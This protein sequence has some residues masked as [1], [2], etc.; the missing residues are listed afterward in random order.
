MNYFLKVI[1][2]HETPDEYF[3]HIKQ[4]YSRSSVEDSALIHYLIN[5]INDPVF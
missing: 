5:G 2:Q 1:I 4:L 3:L